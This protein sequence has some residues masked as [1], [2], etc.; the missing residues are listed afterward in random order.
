M[1]RRLKA[2][3]G[4]DPAL[5]GNQEAEARHRAWALFTPLQPAWREGT[6]RHPRRVHNAAD[7]QSPPVSAWATAPRCQEQ[8]HGK[9]G[10][11]KPQKTQRPVPGSTEVSE[12]GA[13]SSRARRAALQ[14]M[15]HHMPR[16]T[17]SEW[18]HTAKCLPEG[19]STHCGMNGTIDRAQIADQI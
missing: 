8:R 2:S 6:Q 10:C 4:I 18:I 7:Q 9:F 14:P 17:H 16:F 1:A 15:H 13:P 5:T 12:R 19:Q 3:P 11:A